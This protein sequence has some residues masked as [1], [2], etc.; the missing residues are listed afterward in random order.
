MNWDRP[1]VPVQRSGESLTLEAFLGRFI[2]SGRYGVSLTL[3][4]YTGF[5]SSGLSGWIQ[6]FWSV[7]VNSVLLLF[8]FSG[9]SGYI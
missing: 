7:S 8:S 2:L 9:Q 1:T 5:S 3:E 6:S 4:V